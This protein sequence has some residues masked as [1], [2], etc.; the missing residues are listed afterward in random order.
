MTEKTRTGVWNV[1]FQIM[2]K[3]FLD[4]QFMKPELS[5][6][7]VVNYEFI[8]NLVSTTCKSGGA[9]LYGI[10]SKTHTLSG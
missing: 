4:N 6:I 9:E 2:K 8:E 3:T 10:N 1:E 7:L 5:K